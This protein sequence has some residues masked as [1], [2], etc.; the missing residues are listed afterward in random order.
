MVWCWCVVYVTCVAESND[1]DDDDDD[2]V[3]VHPRTTC[4]VA[5][6]VVVAEL[7]TVAALSLS[8]SQK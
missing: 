2:D 5:R 1:D 6:V 8:S 7:T 3:C 4:R